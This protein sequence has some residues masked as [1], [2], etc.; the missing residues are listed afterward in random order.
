M[1]SRNNFPRAQASDMSSSSIKKNTGSRLYSQSS[2]FT[3]L[4]EE[5]FIVLYDGYRRKST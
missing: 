1:L 5:T 2:S 4:L 3:S